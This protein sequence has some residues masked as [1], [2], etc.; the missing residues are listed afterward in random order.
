[1]EV[2]R[3]KSRVYPGRH[4]VRVVIEDEWDYEGERIIEKGEA[5]YFWLQEG[6]THNLAG[7]RY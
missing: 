7:Y 1:M 3:G 2:I 4:F 6:S 5:S